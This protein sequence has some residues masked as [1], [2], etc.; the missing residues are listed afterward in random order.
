VVQ[1]TESGKNSTRVDLRMSYRPAGRRSA[2]ALV[3]A[4]GPDP[5]AV[6]DESL[7]RLQAKFDQDVLTPED[8]V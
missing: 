6:L 8:S 7:A 2:R 4:F 1:F 3:E 5:K